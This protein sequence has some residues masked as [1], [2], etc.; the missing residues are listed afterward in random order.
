MKTLRGAIIGYGNVAAEAHLPGFRGAKGF[1]LA[2][3]V[4]PSEE[5][6]AAAAAALP[7]AR[8][9]AD[10]AG[11]EGVRLDFVDVATPP[12]FHAENVIAALERGWHVLCEK[13]LAIDTAAA[14]EVADAARRTGK[15]VFT[16]HNWKYAPLFQ[17]LRGLVTRGAVGEVREIE[18]RVLRPN[19]PAGATVGGRSWRVDRN[20]AGGGILADHGWHAFYLMQFLFGRAPRS[21]TGRVWN[22][23]PGELE[24]EDSAEVTLD[25][26]GAAA[27]LFFTWAAAERRTSGRVRG[28][29][30][31]IEISDDALEIRPDD[32]DPQTLRF[33]P[34]IAASSYHPEWLPSLLE[35]FRAEVLHLDRRGRNLA[36][37]LCCAEMLAAGYASNGTAIE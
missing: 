27:R 29:G 5:R 23:R 16:V 9:V 22:E 34:S 36:E 10:L 28:S 26:D 33:A 8:V 25:F 21:V 14:V 19:P 32:R 13:P 15:T 17:R 30:G 11:L 31:T 4:D 3:V 1:A 35:D 6:R 2:A 18:W 12:A 7:E 37:A 20:V 24:V